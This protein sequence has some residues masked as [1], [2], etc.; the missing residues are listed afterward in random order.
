MTLSINSLIRSSAVIVALAFL[1]PSPFA[2]TA[3]AAVHPE[4][5][6]PHVAVFI[7]QNLSGKSAP[8][9]E[10]RES[11]IKGITSLGISV[12]DDASLN[13]FMARHRI[14]Y[15]GGIDSASA[16][17]LRS[18]EKIDAVL[19]TAVELYDDG[20]PPKI[21]IL[22]RLVSTGE[23]V[24][25]LWAESAALSGD[26]SPGIL[27][28]GVIS[29]PEELREKAVQSLVYSLARHFS[30]ERAKERPVDE[31]YAP[32]FFYRSA[33]L[34]GDRGYA[35]GIVPFL[36]ESDR[37]YAAEIIVLHFVTELVRQGHF[38]VVEPGVVRQRLL[39]M[40]IIMA[41]G[42]TLT[43]ADYITLSLDADMVLSGTVISYE[44]FLGSVGVP[45][46]DFSIVAIERMS[47]T[48]V[49]SSKSQNTGNDGVFFF[50]RGE[51]NTAGRLTSYM[52]RS[53]VGKVRYGEGPKPEL[54][55][56]PYSPGTV[57]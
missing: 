52:I 34:G 6:K 21:G 56:L 18:E 35:I 22:S 47:K 49:L 20:F 31:R 27:G 44:D 9:R 28:I 40:R 19:I 39:N 41:E 45:K 2:Q 33:A 17:A 48:M 15:T 30:G 46:V 23:G 29:D 5:S 24:E 51:V 54:R 16:L 55:D 14:R 42:M 53:L 3:A 7:P 10:L 1:L 50:D 38:R 11:L 25:I 12:L 13:R 26:D 36:N 8:L 57:D 32:K 37:K 43:D 4:T